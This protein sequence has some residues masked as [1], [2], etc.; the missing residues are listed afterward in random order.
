MFFPYEINCSGF[1]SSLLIL[2]KHERLGSGLSF[3]AALFPSDIGTNPR[4]QMESE[5]EPFTACHGTTR[6][7]GTSTKGCKKQGTE[8][9]CRSP[10]TQR[11][12]TWNQGSCL[13]GNSSVPHGQDFAGFYSRRVASSIHGGVTARSETNRVLATQRSRWW[14]HGTD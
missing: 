2:V 12:D 5:P 7:R 9:S 10:A 4:R 1:N 6:P 13:R 8:M 3:Q 11:S 14:R